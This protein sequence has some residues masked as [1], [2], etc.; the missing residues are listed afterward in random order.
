MNEEKVLERLE[1]W[2]RGIKTGPLL[3]ELWPTHRCNLHCKMCG[4]WIHREKTGNYDVVEEKRNEIDDSRILEIIG[5]AKQLGVEEVLI[6]GGGEPLMRKDVVIE[7]MR[8]VKEFGMYG[9]LNTNG[10]LFSKKDLEEIVEMGWDLIMFSIDG[11]GKTHDWVRGMNGCFET[12]RRNLLLLKEIK[13]ERATNLP[14]ISFNT[15]LTKFLLDE[16]EEL[17]KFAHEVGCNDITLIPLIIFDQKI[18]K[19]KPEDDNKLKY[20]LKEGLS[21]ANKLGIHTNFE[22]LLGNSY[23]D[24]K[25]PLEKGKFENSPCYEPFLHILIK[26]TGE[27]TACCMLENSPENAKEK[28]LKEIWFGEYF[29]NMRKDFVRWKMPEECKNCVHSQFIRNMWIREK[30]KTRTDS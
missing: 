23:E 9:N 22:S 30:L 15:V 21:L 14:R 5:E 2:K 25:E 19:L 8:R 11:V 13:Q 28:S 12:L 3:L 16:L 7:A 18:E 27:T 1:K 20:K 4:T 29:E 10:T 6:T 24:L 17:V 26:A